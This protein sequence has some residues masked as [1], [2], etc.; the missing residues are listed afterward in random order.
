MT[1]N[2][3]EVN[4]LNA[5]YYYGNRLVRVVEDF[6]F[7]L[8]QGESLGLVGES[9]CGKT[10]TAMCIAGLLQPKDWHITGNITVNSQTN[11]K[12][13]GGISM[14]FQ[15]SLSSLNP[16]LTL[17][18]HLVQLWRC[19]HPVSKAEAR[20]RVLG[21]L[22]LVG[23][24]NGDDLLEKY[25]W[26]ISGGMAQR[27]CIASA[28]CSE[29]NLLIADEPTAYLDNLTGS[30]LMRSLRELREKLNLT[31]ILVS[32]DLATIAQ[33]CDRIIVMYTG[34]IVEEGNTLDILKNPA[35]P[36]SKRLVQTFLALE[37]GSREV[38]PIE[39]LVPRF[40]SLPK[41]CSFHPRCRKATARCRLV[42]PEL[43]EFGR[44]RKVACHE[45][46]IVEDE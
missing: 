11:D 1:V 12:K 21:L 19:H 3:I 5:A 29:P 30:L 26:E 31:L 32:H 18:K 44:C 25:P 14:A 33:N 41:G 34:R 38:E 15:D 9:G 10:V 20:E 16:V 37:R 43:K 22:K 17:G 39:G 42:K 46:D 4:E 28:L 8:K 45:V 13:M 35:H 40:Q 2:L 23:L 36:Y 7:S 6:S 24:E 27:V